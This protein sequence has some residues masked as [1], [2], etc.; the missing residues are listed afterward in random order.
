MED[1][2]RNTQDLDLE[3]ILKEFGDQT[4]PLEEQPAQPEPPAPQEPESLGDTRVIPQVTGDTVRLDTTA[5]V[6]AARE[7]L[8]QTQRFELET[9][10]QE[11]KPEP[12]SGNWE[13]EYEQPMGNYVPP[14]PIIF[15]PKSR[16]RELKRKLIAG[17]EKRY[18]EL[19]EQGVGR[20][21]IAMILSMIVV[22]MSAGATVMYELDLIRDDRMKLMIFGQFFALLVSALLG[23]YQLV[24]GIRDIFRLRFSLNSLLVFTFGVCCADGIFG[25]QEL[26]V[27]C[28]AAFSLQVTMSLW[29]A[30][31][32]R[33]TEMGQM[34]TMRKATRLYSLEAEPDYF[35]G[36]TGILRG[37]G[38]VEDF[39]DHYSRPSTPERV[40]AVYALL[41]L[42]AAIAAGVLAGN[43][44]G[45]SAGVQAAAMTLL[46]AAPASFFVTLSRP[47]AILEKRL[48]SLGTVLC[49]W[50]GVKQLARKVA[51]PL[52]HDDLIPQGCVKMNG[53]KFYGI[54]EPDTVVAYVT[55]IIRGHGGGLVPL[56][57]QLLD[58]RNGR[59]YDAE[60][61][62]NYGD[63]GVGGE[64]CGVPV[65]LGTLAFMKDMG[66]EIPEGT[67]VNQAVY[68]AIDGELSGLFAITYEK[69]RSSVAGMQT[70][71]SYRSVRNVL[72]SGDF[73]L[74]EGFI[75]SKFKVR[76]KRIA[77]PD[78][79]V[80]AELRQRKSE[81]EAPALALMTQEGLAPMAYAVTGARA[82]RT[83]SIF[84][85]TIHLLAG[86]LGMAMIL[87]LTWHGALELLTP[88]NMFLYELVWLIPGLLITE[89]TRSI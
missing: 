4:E 78:R 41:A 76:T 86:L 58:S 29:S 39:M 79:E 85:V 47:M 35:E 75:R 12:Y 65:L 10:A 13:P 87:M 3:A 23:S 70:L 60:S 81:T 74:T 59:H 30:Y 49:G 36:R 71:C 42:I 2:L 26:R 37:E 82:L 18:Y 57:E 51:F 25:L 27:P 69:D 20:V 61:L 34:D 43:S 89:W 9:P 62:R 63:G 38:E 80:R 16:L 22:L 21:Q 14:Q 84:G 15:R 77:F 11:S 33:T 88:A 53:V 50:Q 31:H 17:P 67:R 32:E 64:V 83:A 55:A 48:H 8:T 54:R 68:A 73:M 56:F 66:I 45:V 24:D 44:R 52:D 1:K 40:V 28:C 5:V 19:S 46:A 6:K 7:D 72:I